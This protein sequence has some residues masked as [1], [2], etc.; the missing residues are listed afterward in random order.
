MEHVCPYCETTHMNPAYVNVHYGEATY[1]F[2]GFECPK[3]QSRWLT[4][5]EV[6]TGLIQVASKHKNKKVE[7]D[8]TIAVE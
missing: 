8:Y 1:K 3:C 6:I 2:L 5:D 4:R 7:E